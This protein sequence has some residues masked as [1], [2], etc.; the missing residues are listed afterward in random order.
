MVIY[1]KPGIVQV[2]YHPVWNLIGLDWD[3]FSISLDDLKDLHE[4]TLAAAI[5]KR[6]YYFVAETSRVRTVFSEDCITWWVDEW[7]AKLSAAGLKAIVTVV[8]ESALATMS[9]SAWQSE[10]VVAGITMKNVKNWLEALQA[11]KALQQV[12]KNVESPKAL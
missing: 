4:K 11:V 12:N 5:E 6:C 7:V 8:P 9:N 3:S 10:V 1:H 2:T